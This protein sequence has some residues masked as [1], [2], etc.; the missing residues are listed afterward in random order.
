MSKL[1]AIFLVLLSTLFWGINFHAGK[2]VVGYLSPLDSAAIRFTLSSIVVLFMLLV[3]ESPTTIWAAVKTQWKAYILLGI[4][5]I[6]GFN[7]LFFWG[8]KYST[9]VNSA[10][11]MA[12][13]PL[14][15]VLIAA[16]L[17]KDPVRINQYIGMFL[18]L[19]GIILVITQGKWVLLQHF[20][21]A[22]GDWIIMAAN[23]CF[24]LYG[25]LC[26]R[27][28][29]ESKPIITTAMTMIIGT[30]AL[31]FCTSLSPTPSAWFQQSWQVYA[32]VLHMAL[33]GTVLA[34][35]FW[36]SGIIYLGI[37]Q[38]VIFFNL[39]PVFAVLF[40]IMLGQPV[41]LPQM[42]GGI[43]VLLGVLISTN[44]FLNR[45]QALLR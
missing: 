40:A 11:I 1:T 13:N 28:L 19:V 34:Y 42:V 7:G 10:L 43:L 26:R 24:A 35:L 41:L 37:N 9:A 5:G 32:A 36:N 39:V 44:Y 21:I 25:V 15:T 6:A 27:F 31:L 17:L 4:V 16:L 29:K 20:Q 18:S 45:I 23:I 22:F 2:Y 14:V 8:L 30:L 3:A 33:L 38:T 12:T